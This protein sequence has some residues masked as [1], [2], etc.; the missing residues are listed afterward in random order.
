MIFNFRK[1]KK[2]IYTEAGEGKPIV[3][4][5][6][7]MGGLSNFEHQIEF[8]SNHGYKV[9]FLELPLYSLS[10]LKTNILGLTGHVAS[11]LKS[12]VKKPAILIGNSLGGHLALMLTLKKPECVDALVLTGSSGLY[13]RSFGDTYPKRGSYEYIKN[14]SEEVFYDPKVATKELVDQVYETVSDRSKAIKTIQ[15]ARSAMKHNL[16]SEL[17]NIQKD[18]CL[19]WGKQD[20]VTPPEVAVEFNE[21]ISKSQLFWIDKCGHSAMMEKPDEFNK[22]LLKWLKDVNK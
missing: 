15:I 7:L 17:K 18:T 3:L 16:S 1:E 9:Y 22:I 6:G 2:H 4:L 10:P 20:N 12:I 13:E 8:F 11:F 14:K 21:C 19:I 5:H